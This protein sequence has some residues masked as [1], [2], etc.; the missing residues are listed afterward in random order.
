M[1]KGKSEYMLWEVFELPNCNQ[2]GVFL[3]VVKEFIISHL[4]QL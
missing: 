3:G 4:V 1:F 2:I